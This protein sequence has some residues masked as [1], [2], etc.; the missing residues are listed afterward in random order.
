MA[1]FVRKRWLIQRWIRQQYT[2]PPYDAR[3]L[4]AEDFRHKLLLGVGQGLALH[5]LAALL[6]EQG[7]YTEALPVAREALSNLGLAHYR[8]GDHTRAVIR[9]EQ[10]ADVFREI[11]DMPYLAATFT[12]LAGAYDAAGNADAA[13]RDRAEASAILDA[14]PYA[15]AAQVR[16]WIAREAAAP[17]AAVLTPDPRS[18][19][20]D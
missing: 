18:P 16:A 19:A 13:R 9:Y 1:P 12:S 14:L 10:A 6:Q 11:G 15:D 3:G 20:E 2:G 5:G 4:E 8:A 7:R 17:P